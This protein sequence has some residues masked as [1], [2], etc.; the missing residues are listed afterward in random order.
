MPAIRNTTRGT[1]IAA[2][3]RT[4]QRLNE[5]MRGML[6]R[7]FD[8]FDALLFPRNNSIHMFFMHMPLDI[9]FLDA[10]GRACGIRNSLRPWKMAFQRGA[11]TT[12]EL[13]AGALAGSGTRP[14]D[15]IAIG[16]P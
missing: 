1:V 12:V 2:N 9:L 8:G 5:R 13:P 6:G 4:A 10:E 7:G 11:R 3:A 16:E 15:Q 14:G